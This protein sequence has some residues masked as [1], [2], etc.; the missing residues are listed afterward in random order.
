M[1]LMGILVNAAVAIMLRTQLLGLRG[2]T[3]FGK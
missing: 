3:L 2:A 1:V